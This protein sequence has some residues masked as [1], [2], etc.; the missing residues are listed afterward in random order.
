[1]IEGFADRFTN[2]RMRFMDYSTKIA[3]IFEVLAKLEVLFP[4]ADVVQLLE[5]PKE[6]F[7][8]MEEKSSDLGT[9]AIINALDL[10]SI[11]MY[12]PRAES[13]L[14]AIMESM[15]QEECRM[16]VASQQVLKEQRRISQLFIDEVFGKKFS[17][18]LSFYLDRSEGYLHELEILYESVQEDRNGEESMHGKSHESQLSQ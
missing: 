5:S 10:L 6:F 2:I 18:A 13:A 16:F 9:I 17:R 4:D 15:N 11:W 14:K 1:V 7:Q 8:L 3:Q 12:Q